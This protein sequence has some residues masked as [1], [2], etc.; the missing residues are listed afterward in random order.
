MPS[1]LSSSIAINAAI[2]RVAPDVLALL[3]SA[4]AGRAGAT[5]PDT[6]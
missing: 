2:E 5:P 3:A 4:P 6:V 1:R